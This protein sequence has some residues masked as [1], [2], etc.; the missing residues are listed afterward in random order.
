MVSSDFFGHVYYISIND[1]STVR[2]VSDLNCVIN[3]LF[4]KFPARYGVAQETTN[5][6]LGWQSA[7]PLEIYSHR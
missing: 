6:D 7:W 1:N 5:W 2:N 3:H 4:I